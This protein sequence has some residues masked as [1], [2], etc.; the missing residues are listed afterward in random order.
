MRALPAS[1]AAAAIVLAA[2]LNGEG[3]WQQWRGPLATGEAPNADPPIEWS[4]TRNVR[5]KTALPGKGHS[6]PIVTGDRIFVTAAFPTGEPLEPRHD[7]AHG[8]HHDVAVTHRHEFAVI[9]ID[10]A[11][12][13]IVWQQTVHSELPHEGGHITGSYAS[14]SPITDGELL[15]AFFGSRGLYALDLDGKVQWELDLGGMETKHAHGEGASPALYDDTLIVNWDHEGPSFLVALDKKSGT[16]RWRAQRDE[17]SSWATPIVVEHEGKA[18]VIVSGTDR[19]RAY[20]L[21]SGRVIWECGGLSANVVAS[22]V[23]GD[24]IV[25]AGSSYDSQALLAIRLA[26][27]EGDVTGSS[28]IVWSRDRGTPYVPSP[29]LYDGSLYYL[30]HYQGILSRVEAKSG[31][32]PT[33]PFRL[34][35]VREIYASPIA[36]AGRIYITDRQGTTIVFTSEE[37][38][39]LLAINRLDDTFSASPAA[40]G[41]ELYLRGESSLYSLAEAP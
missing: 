12:G 14:A 1:I 25:F 11:D 6:T 31:T 41:S 39:E 8:T 4:E 28:Q 29:L 37:T 30:R 7:T 16:E 21:E 22:P 36:A 27:A 34:S 20:D 13:V 23:A 17:V 5:W 10:R 18:Q 19:I 32:E 2:P 40:V 24:G 33:G 35:A 38:P 3:S 9:A 26:G 15:F